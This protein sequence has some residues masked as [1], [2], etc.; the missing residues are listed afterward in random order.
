MTVPK[1]IR[2]GKVAVIVSPGYGAGWST[3]LGSETRQR[4]EEAVFCPDLVTAIEA[5][6]AAAVKECAARIFGPDAYLGGLVRDD[7]RGITA[8]VQWVPVG[9]RFEIS[10]YD[11]FETL[12]ILD[13]LDGYVA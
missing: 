11:G 4:Q 1:L 7:E 5:G 2:D 8:R 10:E 12:R 13:P 3:W 9:T 6:D